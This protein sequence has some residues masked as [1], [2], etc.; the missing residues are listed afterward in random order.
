MTSH[1]FFV[2]LA[3][4]FLK[5]KVQWDRPR[6]IS[7]TY[8]KA[9][10]AKPVKHCSQVTRRK[11]CSACSGS[12]RLP[13]RRSPSAISAASLVSHERNESRTRCLAAA[14]CGQGASKK[15]PTPNTS[16]CRVW[17]TSRVQPSARKI[18]VQ[19]VC[20]LVH[21]CYAPAIDFKRIQTVAFW[22]FS[23]NFPSWSSNPFR[24]LQNS[25]RT[26]WRARDTTGLL[27]FQ[28]AFRWCAY[29]NYITSSAHTMAAIETIIA[30]QFYC[31]SYVPM[32]LNFLLGW[33][34]ANTKPFLFR[35]M[36][37]VSRKELKSATCSQLSRPS[38]QT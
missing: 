35:I 36:S 25:S 29:I 16:W 15:R 5:H 18:E 12:S 4:K 2:N 8:F 34:G 23:T 9:W 7:H 32:L 20:Y 26:A 37:M 10:T 27:D 30:S 13:F 11:T 38:S 31:K 3:A 14:L 28:I 17:G 6:V 22:I 24:L 33:M 19:V 1:G 21:L